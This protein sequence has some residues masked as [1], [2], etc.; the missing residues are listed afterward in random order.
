MKYHRL[1]ELTFFFL[2]LRKC[3]GFLLLLLKLCLSQPKLDVDPTE[4]LAS[5][6]GMM[7]RRVVGV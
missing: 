7:N 6:C 2:S 3:L 5:L 4:R 1:C